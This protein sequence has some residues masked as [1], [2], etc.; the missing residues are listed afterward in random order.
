MFLCCFQNYGLKAGMPNST[1]YN[2]LQDRHRFFWI[3]TQTGMVR[4]DGVEFTQFLPPEDDG[5][6]KPNPIGLNKGRRTIPLV[7]LR[8]SQDDKA[9]QKREY[10]LY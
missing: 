4:Y 10:C 7:R 9:W 5:N 1:V 8:M 6:I 2:M 3:A